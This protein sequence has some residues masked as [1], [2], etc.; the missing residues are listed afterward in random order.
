MYLDIIAIGGSPLLPVLGGTPAI[1]Y[2]VHMRRFDS[3][4]MLDSQLENGCLTPLQ[5]DQFASNIA[6]FHRTL[7]PAP[8][9]SPFCQLTAVVEPAVQNFALLER[10]LSE[11]D[12][13]RLLET[14]RLEC[15]QEF[16]AGENFF[17]QR[18]E[19]GYVRECHGD[20]HLGNLVLLEGKILPFDG[21]EFNA[22]LRWIDVI[23]DIAFT[24]MD[25]L[26]HSQPQLAWHLLDGYLQHSGNYFSVSVLRYYLAYR[27]VVR[28]KVAA[29]R[30]SA[31]S[32]GQFS[33]CHRYLELAHYFLTNRRPALII[34]HG[35]PGSGKSTFAQLA[36]ERLG[37]LRIR[38]D[39]ERKRLYGLAPLADSGAKIYQQD[40]THRTYARLLELAQLILEARFPVIVDAACLLYAER[41]SFRALARELGVPFVIA[42]LQTELE[43]LEQRLKQR[44]KTGNDVSEAD[45][46][47]MQKLSAIQEPLQADEPVV[48]FHNNQAGMTELAWHSLEN[49]ILHA[50]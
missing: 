18:A 12:D 50:T 9:A 36:L 35:L 25:L 3:G 8:L 22:A 44:S 19:S 42:H 29:L 23:S 46:S 33:V 11:P 37:A 43:I 31:Q 40:A 21:I 15:L 5:I 20:L 32:T 38:S 26:Q 13:R 24:V 34:T 16:V 4:C 7:V 30:A 49:H 41:E 48:I 45:I 47:V 10:L 28:A 1:E 17:R 2:A 39:V 14:L 6:E 27:S